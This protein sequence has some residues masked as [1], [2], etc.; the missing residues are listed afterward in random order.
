MY[1]NLQL[2]KESTRNNPSIFSIDQNIRATRESQFKGFDTF[3][4]EIRLN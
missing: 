3:K 4:E 2:Y 1:R